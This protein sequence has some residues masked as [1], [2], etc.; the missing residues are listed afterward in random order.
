MNELRIIAN[1]YSASDFAMLWNTVWNG[2]P[3][4]PQIELALKHS[5]YR[6][7]VYDGERIIGMA[8]MIGDLGMCYYI[9]DVIVHPDY[10]RRGIGKMMIGELLRFIRENGV[11][12]TE[13]AVELYAMPD[14]IPFYETFGF[15]ANEAQRLRI[16]P[17]TEKETS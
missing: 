2:C 7:G 8:R 4:L 10:Q 15:K 5:V 13:I 17:R 9:K 3:S 12:D 16:M 11:P 14:K 6:V 1:T